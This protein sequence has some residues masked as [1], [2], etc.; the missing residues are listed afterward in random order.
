M[1]HPGT[2]GPTALVLALL[3]LRPTETRAAEKDGAWVELKS[4]NFTVV[5]NDGEGAARQTAKE[6]EQIR[7]VFAKLLVKVDTGRPQGTPE[8][9]LKQAAD[10]RILLP[11]PARAGSGQ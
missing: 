2:F 9:V 10:R 7:S 4:P 5:C 6:F 1:R 11:R 8:A 3:T